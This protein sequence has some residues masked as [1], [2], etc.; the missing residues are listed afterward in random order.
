MWVEAEG[1]G[2]T[3]LTEDMP[4]WQDLVQAVPKYLSGAMA[5]YEWW[6]RVISPTFELCWTQIW[7]GT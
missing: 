1:V 5:E 7:P 4:G 3:E 2:L 6:D